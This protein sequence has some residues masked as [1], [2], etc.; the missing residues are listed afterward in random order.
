MSTDLINRSE[1]GSKYSC[2]TPTTMRRLPR[3]GESSPAGMRANQS[4]YVEETNE[5]RSRR[6]YDGNL[7][8]QLA[9]A[10]E[11]ADEEE[12]DLCNWH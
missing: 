12:R 5:I 7:N 10:M 2:A 4:A 11:I 1:A 6:S 8:P 3:L 9:Q